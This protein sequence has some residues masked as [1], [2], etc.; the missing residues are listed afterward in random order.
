MQGPQRLR[1]RFLAL[2]LGAAVPMSTATAVFIW[3]LIPLTLAASGSGPA[4]IARV[5]MLYYLPVVLLGSLVTTWADGRIGPTPLLVTGALGSGAALLSLTAWSGFWAVVVTVA[6]FGIGH[7]LL[8]APLYA[9]ADRLSNGSDK[10][11]AALRLFERV[12]AIAG[13]VASAWFLPQAGAQT[14]IRM[15]GFVVLAGI[16]V[17]GIADIVGRYR[18][19][20]RED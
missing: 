1:R 5:V 13:L 9:L 16:A 8:R 4:E 6:A 7:T 17:Y 2:L 18:S 10:A 3:Y 15:M 14:S 11:R 20:P 12:G 19:T